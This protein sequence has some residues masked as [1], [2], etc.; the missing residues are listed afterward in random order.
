[1]PSPGMERLFWQMGRMK[2]L[3][4]STVQKAIQQ[5][6]EEHEEQLWLSTASG[7]DSRRLDLHTGD[8]VYMFAFREDE[9]V[10]VIRQSTE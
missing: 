9:A 8:P 4:H 6:T 5:R 10:S 7:S 1:M 2:S 3:F